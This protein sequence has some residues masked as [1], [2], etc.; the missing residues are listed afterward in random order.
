MHRVQIGEYNFG[1]LDDRQKHSVI[2]K[3]ARELFENRDRIEKA[4]EWTKAAEE[5]RALLRTGAPSDEEIGEY[6]EKQYIVRG[7]RKARRG[8]TNESEAL[9]DW[10][11]AEEEVSRG[12]YTVFLPVSKV[13]QLVPISVLHGYAV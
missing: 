7:E 11:E 9:G 6:F 8:V 12:H 13:P 5:L 1:D 4:E 2:Q 10:A 3:R